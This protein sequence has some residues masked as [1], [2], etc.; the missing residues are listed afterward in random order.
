[1]STALILASETAVSISAEAERM[2]LEALERA[3]L[4]GTVTTAEQNEAAAKIQR[5]IQAVVKAVEAARKAAKEPF[6][7]MGRKIDAKARKFSEDLESEY[8]RIGECCQEFVTAQR[9]KFLAEQR[10]VAEEQARVLREQQQAEAEARAKAEAEAA[11][12]RNEEERLAA[13]KRAEEA[14]KAV[15]ERAQQELESIRPA[16]LPAKAEGQVVK[17]IWEWSVTDVWL[18]ARTSPGL[19]RIEPNRQEINEVITRLAESVTVPQIA[20]L[21]I[22]SETKVTTRATKP[23]VI[24]V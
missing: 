23:K 4:I 15:A 1:V 13:Q 16:A 21:R 10:R 14:A 24:D 12:A 5:D 3:A 11:A 18:L 9:E 2:K 20:G 7:D 19:V 22:W 8:H 6:F 17:P